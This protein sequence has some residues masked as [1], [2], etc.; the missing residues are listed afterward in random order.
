MPSR[1]K[2]D[3]RDTTGE[4][5]FV[6]AHGHGPALLLLHGFGGSARNFRPQARALRGRWRVLLPDVRGHA[7]SPR[8]EGPGACTAERLVADVVRVLDREGAARAV[9]GGL[10]MGAALAL[11]VALAH[12]D[13]VQALVLASFPAAGPGGL[14]PVATRFAD[15]LERDGLEAAGAEFVWGAKSGFDRSAAAFVRQGFLEHD[16]RSLAAVLRDFLAR[17]PSLDARAPQLTA[18]AAP[19]L[20]IAGEA[21]A[22]SLA[23][24]RALAALLPR[25][26]LAVIPGAGHVVNLSAP[27][28][29]NAVVSTFLDSLPRD[30]D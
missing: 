30:A 25:A 29:F 18:L 4:D 7:R 12:P 13:R 6:E 21:D 17:L 22:I 23:P 20:V 27:A 1:A 16:A 24:S 8:A 19:A 26:E 3:A 10:S 28:A 11:E 2:E 9:V 14:T 5:L 15:V